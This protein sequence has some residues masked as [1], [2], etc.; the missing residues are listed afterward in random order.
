[1]V[2]LFFNVGGFA[3]VD[4]HAVAED[5]LAVEGF[6]DLDGCVD[7]EEGYDD[8]SEGFEGRE[9]VKWVLGFDCGFDGCQVGLGED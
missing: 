1:M 4:A 5:C 3:K 8:A 7:G 6:A 2:V 9:R